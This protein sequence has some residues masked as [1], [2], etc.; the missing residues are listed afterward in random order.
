MWCGEKVHVCGMYL[1]RLL[2]NPRNQNPIP[3]GRCNTFDLGSLSGSLEGV[4]TGEEALQVEA[5]GFGFDPGC[6][7]VLLYAFLTRSRTEGVLSQ[8]AGAF[9]AE[10][11][12][13]L[14]QVAVVLHLA[15]LI[16]LF[17][18]GLLGQL[19]DLD[20]A[21][22]EVVDGDG[23]GELDVCGAGAAAA[24]AGLEVTHLQGEF[25]GGGL[26]V[27]PERLRG[28]VSGAPALIKLQRLVG[29]EGEA[30]LAAVGQLGDAQVAAAGS[31][32]EVGARLFGEK[33]HL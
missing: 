19:E 18:D 14:Q 16:Q 11:E 6:V 8:E 32:G 9:L 3:N 26:V 4:A 22:V 17:E 10:D 20:V 30:D 5:G 27:E 31:C 15:D 13:P 29:E 2:H 24:F 12:V 25:F 23:D 7:N 1:N 33:G 28:A 21:V